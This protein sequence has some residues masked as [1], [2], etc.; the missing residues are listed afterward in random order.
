MAAFPTFTM[1]TRRLMGIAS[2][3]LVLALVPAL[4]AAVPDGCIAVG[5][6]TEIGGHRSWDCFFT[7]TGPSYYSANTPNPYV[8]AISKDGGA[9]WNEVVHPGR[10]GAPR[11]G[12][13]RSQQ[14]DLVSVSITCWDFVTSRPCGGRLGAGGRFGTVIVN[15]KP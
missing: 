11:T 14:G 9:T 3:A 13:I 4:G 15:S 1:L 7:A 2:L 10:P 6:Q 8:I 5:A 12:V